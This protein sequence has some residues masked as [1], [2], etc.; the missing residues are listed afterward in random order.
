MQIKYI[1]IIIIFISSCNVFSEQNKQST[2]DSLQVPK[3]MQYPK[4]SSPAPDSKSKDNEATVINVEPTLTRPQLFLVM[5][6]Q[7]TNEKDAH[8]KLKVILNNLSYI[9]KKNNLETVAPM[10]AWHTQKPF[11][12]IEEG[13]LPLATQLKYNEPGTYYKRI[14]REKAVVAHFFGKRSLL[15]QAYDSLYAW[16]KDNNQQPKGYPWEEYTSDHKVMKDNSF[17][18]TDVYILVK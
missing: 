14:K 18:E 13:G 10:V 9:Q 17:L 12:Y 3:S 11:T 16:L 6:D 2:Q 15:N 1:L 5:K 7:A 4:Q 8:E